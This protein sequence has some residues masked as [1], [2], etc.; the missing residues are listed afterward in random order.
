MFF[1]PKIPVRDQR[2][3]ATTLDQCAAFVPGKGT[4]MQ[5]EAIPFRV[6]ATLHNDAHDAF[7]TLP[8]PHDDAHDAFMT[9]PPL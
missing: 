2:N 1:T 8:L 9:L 5:L 7:M 4:G 6:S 3:V